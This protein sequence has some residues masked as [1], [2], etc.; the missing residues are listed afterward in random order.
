M[1]KIDTC[2]ELEKIYS[3]YFIFFLNKN[4]GGR[5]PGWAGRRLA[6]QSLAMQHLASSRE[7]KLSIMRNGDIYRFSALQYVNLYPDLFQFCT[8]LLFCNCIK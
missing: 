1:D 7:E 5:W 3:L 8:K 4:Q 6:H 2:I